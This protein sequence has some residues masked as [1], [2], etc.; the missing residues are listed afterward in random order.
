MLGAEQFNHFHGL[1][2]FVCDGISSFHPC[3]LSVMLGDDEFH[4]HNYESLI[5]MK[6]FA[7][8]KSKTRET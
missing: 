1:L 5:V 6:C 7:S 3:I 8:I 4:A 2:F